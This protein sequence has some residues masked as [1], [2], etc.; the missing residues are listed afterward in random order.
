LASIRNIQTSKAPFKH[1]Q[2]EIIQFMQV[3]YQFDAIEFRKVNWLYRQ[4]G[5]QNR[6]SV[7]SDFTEGEEVRLF[8]DRTQEVGIEERLAVYNRE[9]YQMSL[10]LLKGYSAKEL[11]SVTHLITV[12]CTGITA[13]G[14]ELKLLE[15][16][17]LDAS[18]RAINFMGCYA[19]IHAMKQAQE[20]CALHP[21]AK[22][23]VVDIELCTLHFQYNTQPDLVN[24]AMIFGDGGAS[25][26]VEL[27]DGLELIGSFNKVL[28]H[29]KDKMAWF[30]SATGFLMQLSSYIPQVIGDNIKSLINDTVNHFNI[31]DLSK[32]TWC[33]HPGGLKI[34]DKIANV[35]DLAKEELVSSY[36]ILSEYGNMSSP[37]VMYVLQRLIEKKRIPKG[38][39]V[40]MLAFGPGLSIET[41]LLQA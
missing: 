16:L 37:T 30:P 9:A 28:H 39:Q 40:L 31:S 7:L 10:N 12:S 33:I 1:N 21:D 27:G 41:T 35:M 14:L 3:F 13:P 26:I 38:N 23:L 15:H 4:S 32:V 6:Y 2:M 8:K 19:A 20:I 25:W 5:I 36:E 18:Q 17:E 22:V 24:S 34:L 11:K 29:D